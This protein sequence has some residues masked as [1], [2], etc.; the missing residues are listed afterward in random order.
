MAQKVKELLLLLKESSVLGFQLFDSSLILRDEDRGE[1]LFCAWPVVGVFRE[2][3]SNGIQDFWGIQRLHLWRILELSVSQIS[4]FFSICGQFFKCDEFIGCYSQAENIRLLEVRHQRLQ[5]AAEKLLRQVP[6]VSF[7]NVDF[8]SDLREES[9]HSQISEFIV[10]IFALQDVSWFDI[11][12]ND[13]LT[14]KFMETKKNIPDDF[15]KIFFWD[16]SLKF[17]LTL[18][19]R[20]PFLLLLGFLLDLLERLLAQLHDNMNPIFFDPAVEIPD[21]VRTLRFNTQ[22]RERL[23]LLQ[24]ICLFILA[25]DTMFCHFDGVLEFVRLVLA[26]QNL[27]EVAFSQDSKSGKLFIKPGDVLDWLILL[28]L[29]ELLLQCL[30]TESCTRE[31]GLLFSSLSSI[32]SLT[33]GGTISILKLIYTEIIVL[34]S[35]VPLFISL[36]AIRVKRAGNHTLF[37][38][39]SVR[40]R[41]LWIPLENTMVI[42]HWCLRPSIAL[43]IR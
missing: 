41:N 35:F 33:S 31:V 17:I 5:I 25:S 3:P 37:I 6:T 20:C 21:D 13:V 12:M 27:T 7:R 9:R 4:P 14:V 10:I 16:I 32:L 34:W 18:A 19:L 26:S 43:P 29:D 42:M 30:W 8:F 11:Q 28:K 40:P 38:H 39:G 36:I 15:A 24:V 22:R 1:E 2:H 23:H